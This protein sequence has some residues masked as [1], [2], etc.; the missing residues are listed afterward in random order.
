MKV[1]LVARGQTFDPGS[2]WM[3]LIEPSRADRVN[4]LWTKWVVLIISTGA[5]KTLFMRV[6]HAM[7]T[8]TFFL[9][10]PNLIL[11][12]PVKSIW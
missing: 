2:L 1:A 3:K 6:W 10:F 7:S 11:K 8:Q 4:K 9:E 5:N 12:G